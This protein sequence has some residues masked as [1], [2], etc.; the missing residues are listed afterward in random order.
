[1]GFLHLLF[2]IMLCLYISQVAHA[3]GE[4]Q[5]VCELRNEV[6]V[7]DHLGAAPRAQVQVISQK[8]VFVTNGSKGTYINLNSSSSWK[9]PLAVHSDGIKVTLV[10]QN[11]SDNLFVATIFRNRKGGQHEIIFSLH[12]ESQKIEHYFPKQLYGT[13][14]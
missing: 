13:C 3:S 1:M 4:E 11:T 5:F 9:G 14:D 2:C 6:V 10:E 8:Y 12:S 7:A